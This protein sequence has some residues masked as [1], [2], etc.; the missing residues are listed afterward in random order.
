MTEMEKLA[1]IIGSVSVA[2]NNWQSL[3]CTFEYGEMVYF[4]NTKWPVVCL[5]T[6][7]TSLHLWLLSSIKVSS[8]PTMTYQFLH[9]TS[10]ADGRRPFS[11]TTLILNTRFVLFTT[12]LDQFFFHYCISCCLLRAAP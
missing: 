7:W 4:L 2:S 9:S 5:D 6:R 12:G 11:I 3:H 10:I 8:T 1:K